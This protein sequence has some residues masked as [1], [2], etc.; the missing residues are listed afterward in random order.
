MPSRRPVGLHIHPYPTTVIHYQVSSMI[1]NRLDQ[2][3]TLMRVVLSITIDL[4]G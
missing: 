2:Q 4:H 3:P 1:H